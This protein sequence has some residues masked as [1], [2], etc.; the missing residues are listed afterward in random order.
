MVAKRGIAMI[1]LIF[2]LVIIG[3]VLMSAPMLIQQSI[4]SSN[5][6][7]QQEAISAAAS[8]VSIVLSM[9]WDENN[10]NLP[11]GVSPILETNRSSFSF[12]T[13]PLGVTAPS[14][15]VDV[16]SR[17]SKDINTTLIPTPIANFGKNKDANETVY[18][19]FDDV[20]DYH[21]TSFGLMVFNNEDVSADVG[22]YVD[23]DLNLSTKINYADDTVA[24]Q[25]NIQDNN[26]TDI[27]NISAGVVTNIK[28]IQLH[29][30]S[31]N[32]A[33]ELNKSIIMNAFSCNIGT[34]SIEGKS[35]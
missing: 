28:F 32:E 10:S 14:G 7:L 9:N 1:E 30:T 24:L 26:I 17:N 29:L 25:S 15:L 21:D 4:K 22:E 16:A 8:Q 35:L 3:I 33:E 31:N 5:V 19:D 20:D 12:T 6:A 27:N 34:Y 13:A 23:V 11:A 2:A 18:T